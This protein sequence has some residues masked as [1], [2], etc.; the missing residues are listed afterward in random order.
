M[1]ENPAPLV[2][3][4]GYPEE[5]DYMAKGKLV[6]CTYVSDSAKPVNLGVV[7]FIAGQNPQGKTYLYDYLLPP[8]L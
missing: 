6:G 2:Q 1:I 5:T 4:L 8:S 7:A 3:P